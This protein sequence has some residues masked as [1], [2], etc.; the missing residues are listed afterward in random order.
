MSIK[1]IDGIR[2]HGGR[3]EGDWFDNSFHRLILSMMKL[4]GRNFEQCELCPTSIPKGKF[5]LHHTRY[6]GA[7]YY[8]LRIVCQKCNHAPANVGLQ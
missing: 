2:Y 4:E 1:V 8:D 5:S 3:P 7:T 6:E